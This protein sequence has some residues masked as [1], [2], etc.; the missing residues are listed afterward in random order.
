MSQDYKNTLNLPQTDF[1]MQAGLPKKEP[2]MLE[3]WE[4]DGIYDKLMKK[5]EGKPRFVLHDGP[6]Y[7]NGDIHLGTALNKTLK[8][9]IVRYKNMSGFQAPYVPGW[10]THGLPTELKARKKAGVDNS[11]TISDVELREMCRE[12]TLGYLDD[13]RKQFKRIGGLGEWDN[14]YITLT[15]DFEATQIEIF[16]KMATSGYIYKGLKPV[17]W[18]PDCVTALAEAEIEYAE[19]PC[20]S[21]YVK[22]AVSDDK[23]ILSK[24][25][26]DPD[27]TYF[28]IWTTTTWTLPANLAICVGPEFDYSIVKCDGEY[29]IMATALYEK[30]MEAAGKAEYEVVASLKGA[31]ME[32]MKAKHP[33]IDRESL[34]IVGDHVTLESGTGC[35]HTAPGHGVDDYNVCKNNYPELPIIVPVDNHGKMTA[36]AGEQFAGLST[37]EASRAI[38]KHLEEIGAM[39]AAKRI[40]HQYPHCWRC[41]NPVL[42]R[43]TEQWF[44]SVDDIK[45]QAVKA[46]QDV[47][48]IPGWGQDRITRL[49]SCGGSFPPVLPS[50]SLAVLVCWFRRHRLRIFRRSSERI[51]SP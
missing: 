44:C 40:V 28:V 23:G 32:Y 13:Q 47:T 12:F 41:K 21:I 34:V 15:R 3:K 18:C 14:P 19:D 25:G 33:F 5:N 8:D 39:F 11:S 31:E 22:F 29:Y 7:A 45:E 37:D 20:Y 36:E 46:I 48:W 26:V 1:S 42:F 4:Q 35:V 27:K 10:D 6:P 16:S 49:R 43:A 30:A 50:G 51:W 9:F 38:G 24:L 2:V 17:H